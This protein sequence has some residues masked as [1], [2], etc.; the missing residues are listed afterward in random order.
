MIASDLKFV[1]PDSIS[2]YDARQSVPKVPVAGPRHMTRPEAQRFLARRLYGIP[3]AV[4]KFRALLDVHVVV[5]F[6]MHFRA[7]FHMWLTIWWCDGGALCKCQLFLQLHRRLV[8]WPAPSRHPVTWRLKLQP[9][10]NFLLPV[11][12][13]AL[14]LSPTCRSTTRSLAIAGH[15]IIE[16]NRRGSSHICVPNPSVFAVLMC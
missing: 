2:V 16:T 8:Q 9:P 1:D 7:C 6:V 5:G 4:R 12:Y 11:R 13:N 3:K 15:S 10:T 14:T